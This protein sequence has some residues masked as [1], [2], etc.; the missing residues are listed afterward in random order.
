MAL[1]AAAIVWSG[2]WKRLSWIPFQRGQLASCQRA[3]IAR[4]ATEA[5]AA[6][7][8]ACLGPEIERRWTVNE[9]RAHH[10]QAM[11][12]LA[13]DGTLDRCSAGGPEP[14][15][16]SPGAA[17]WR[18]RTWAPWHRYEVGRCVSHQAESASD[19][20]KAA[21]CECLYA[22]IQT[23]WSMREYRLQSDDAWRALTGDGTVGRCW[24]PSRSGPATIAGP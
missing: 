23:R 2:V 11:L 12:T 15:A 17:E 1:A 16:G 9:Y 14:A 20:Q 8:C 5:E 10:E 13:D 21:Y 24:D 18:R 19:A 3:S 7:Y 22:V 6:A 4:G